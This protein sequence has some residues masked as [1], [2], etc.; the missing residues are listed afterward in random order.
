MNSASRILATTA[1]A[2]SLVAPLTG[3]LAAPL[4]SASY[5]NTQTQYSDIGH[6]DGFAASLGY[7]IDPWPVFIEAEVFNSGRLDYQFSAGDDDRVKFEGSKL[8][9]GLVLQERYYAVYAKAGYYNF[10][11]RARHSSVD[12]G[13]FPT[14]TQQTVHENQDGLTL[15]VGADLMVLPTLGLRLEFEVPFGVDTAPEV[16]GKQSDLTVLKAGLVWRPA[17]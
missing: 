17:R 2:C 1:A 11:T 15:A 5:A 3:A 8:Y 13:L 10:D 6:G 9:A 16:S 4:V 12:G 14:V 7:V